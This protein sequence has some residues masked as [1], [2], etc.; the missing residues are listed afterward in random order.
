MAPKLV[1]P[2]NDD[3]SRLICLDCRW[4]DCENEDEFDVGYVSDPSS[5]QKKKKQIS[6]SFVQ[7]RDEKVSS[8]GV[9][10]QAPNDPT[11]YKD[12]K[13]KGTFSWKERPSPPR[14][15][16]MRYWG[17]RLGKRRERLFLSIAARTKGDVVSQTKT[18]R[19]FFL[20]R[21]IHPR[22]KSIISCLKRMANPDAR[23]RKGVMCCVSHQSSDAISIVWCYFD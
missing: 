20:T 18:T 6:K 2:G 22:K 10:Q 5:G 4:L 14:K 17:K 8:A 23:L 16:E 13:E 7:E 9:Y 19:F 21:W 11:Q 15:D 3:S 1:K 12:K